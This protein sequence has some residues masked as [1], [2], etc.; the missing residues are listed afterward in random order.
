[1]AGSKVSI[2]VPSFNQGK[3]VRRTLNSLVSEAKQ[4]DLEVIVQDAGSSDETHEILADFRQHS[5]VKICIEP[6]SGQSDALNKGFRKASGNILGWLNSDDVLI[7]GSMRSVIEG[8][9]K[10][11]D[12][13]LVYGDALFIDEND[14]IIEAYPT[15]DLTSE[16]LRDRC[17]ISQPST[18]FTKKAYERYGPFRDDLHFCMDYE[19]WTRLLVNGASVLRLRETVSC[20]RIH[21]ETKTSNGGLAFIDEIV[22]MQECLLGEASPVWQVYKKTRSAP[23][24]HL[25]LKPL[26]FGIAAFQQVLKNPSFI[27]DACRSIKERRLAVYRSRKLLKSFGE[28]IE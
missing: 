20:T 24:N 22:R 8:F 21:D 25:S 2:V 26:R 15:G 3:Y 10:N 17:V 9:H 4:V 23:L 14:K 11:P 6:D 12:T 1:M 18:F 27:V 28:Q 5:F 7:D 13:D 16:V 19:Y